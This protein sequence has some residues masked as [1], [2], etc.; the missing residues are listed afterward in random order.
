MGSLQTP[1]GKPMLKHW[2]FDPSYRNLNHGSFG[3]HPAA[4]RDVQR[5][6]LDLA[7]LRPD[8][9]I[10]VQHA[11][12]LEEARGGL[13]KILNAAKDECVFVKNAT[14]GVATVLYNL[15]FQAGEAVVYFE[16]VY[17]AVEKG[18]VSLQEHSSLQTRKVPFQFPISEGELER[19]FR[20]VVQ[21]TRAEG[22]KVRAAVFD[23]IVSNPGVRFPFE[24]FTAI[25][26]EEG[27]LSV[28]DGAHGIGH[29]HLDMGKLQ[30]D[31]FISNCH[32]WLYTPRSAA[33]LYVP[34]R[35]QHLLR[36][37]L[38]TSWGFIPGADSPAT[39]ASV[40]QD[41]NSVK[42]KTP[43]EEL[44]EFVATSDD[45]AYI[46]VPAAL[47]FRQEVCGGED[48]IIS[49]CIKLANEAADA[50]AAIL[51]TDVMQEPDLKPGEKSS[52][53][54]CA[55]TTV[56]LPIGVSDDGSAVPGAAVTVTSQDA[57]RVFGWIQTTLMEKHDT[58]VPVFRHGPW[59]WTR[60]SAQVF[61]EKSDFEWLGGILREM[62]N[63]VVRKEQPKL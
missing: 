20:D 44:F 2:L 27:I 25:C 61:L 48:A 57:A 1:F 47:K 39:M 54:Q 46:C 14:T 59:L 28:I 36:T 35:N 63:R 13:A 4:V 31:F 6:F 8:P 52:M 12:L 19:Q 3:A 49:Y 11:K 58:F 17:G 33:V 30:P 34:K 10:R 38:P 53:R 40:L 42:T 51:G 15:N 56:R 5:A 50:V 37:T 24:R 16:P 55:M 45:S 29:I 23:A 22:L 62:C 18:L 43:F 60:L 9:Y 26:R 41:A 32:K 21:K 7:D